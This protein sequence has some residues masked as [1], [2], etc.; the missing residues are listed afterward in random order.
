MS[1]PIGYF[2]GYTPGNGGLLG[3][4]ESSWGDFFEQLNQS[5]KF[6]LLYSICGSL[7]AEK[8]AFYNPHDVSDV[9]VSATERLDELHFTDRLGLAQFIIDKLKR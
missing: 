6:W 2:C 1:K 3:E 9:L 8:S 5:E 4:M 7:T